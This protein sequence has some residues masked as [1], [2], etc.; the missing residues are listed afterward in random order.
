M[1][2]VSRLGAAPTLVS[3]KG[4]TLCEGDALGAPLP[5]EAHGEVGARERLLYI[6]LRQV[7]QL[8]VREW[9][10]VRREA[11][12]GSQVARVGTRQWARQAGRFGRTLR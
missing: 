6:E 4:Q 8:R 1:H 12:G 3:S 5:I 10:R 2:N 7:A 9:T 11:S